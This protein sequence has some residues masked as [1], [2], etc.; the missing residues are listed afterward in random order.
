MS[1]TTEDRLLDGRLRL[2]Q[3]AKG[4]RAG[5]D[6]AL[7]AAA[8][9]AGDGARVIEAG[10]GAGAVLLAAAIRRP[11]ARFLG[12]ERDAAAAALARANAAANGL[13]ERVEVI[14]G[15][16]AQPFARLGLEPFDA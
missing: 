5:L 6:A 14:E 16:V 11:G 12:L 4:Y 8:C 9:D 1:E 3:P 10:C 2:R 7:L 15:D 13:S